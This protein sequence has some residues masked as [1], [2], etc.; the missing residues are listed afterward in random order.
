MATGHDMAMGLR[1]AY[2]AIHRQTDARCAKRGATADQFVLLALL[3]EEDGITQQELVRRASSDPNTIRAM[4][5]LL[6]RRGLVARERHPTDGRARRVILTRKGRQTLEKLWTATEPLRKRLLAPL[7]SEETD[8]LV[9][10]LAR[11]S[12]AMTQAGRRDRSRSETSAATA[13]R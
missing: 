5:V 11:I 7:R 8:M 3:G 1:A 13:D 12:E 10:L 6:E 4:L 9:E 2:W